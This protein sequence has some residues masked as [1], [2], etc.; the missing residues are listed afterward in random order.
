MTLRVRGRV[1]ETTHEHPWWVV[2]KGWVASN[3]LAACDVFVTS[4][5]AEV[6]LESVGDADRYVAVHNL[7]V[8]ADHTYFVGDADWDFD[9]FV[10]SEHAEVMLESVGDANRYLAVYN[11]EVEADHTYFVGDTDWGFDVWSHNQHDFSVNP[12]DLTTRLGFQPTEVGVTPDGTVRMVWEPTP[13]TRIRYENHPGGLTLQRGTLRSPLDR[14]ACGAS[15]RPSS[16]R[17]RSGVP[18]TDDVPDVPHGSEPEIAGTVDRAE[19]FAPA[20]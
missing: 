10:T 15:G 5:H 3:N 7:T 1:I 18:W 19:K 11:L 4:E 16:D 12:N 2:G 6:T 14:K 9:V 13:N 20:L 8:E 17:N